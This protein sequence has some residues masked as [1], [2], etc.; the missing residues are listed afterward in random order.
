MNS[1]GYAG[2]CFLVAG[3][4]AAGTASAVGNDESTPE[5]GAFSLLLE[6]D[7]FARQDRHYTNGLQ[8]S[9]L[10]A[11]RPDGSLAAHAINWLPGNGNAKVR[12]G[13]QLG[14]SLFTP[15]DK[16]ASDLLPDERPYAGWLYAGFSL[17]SSTAVHVD[18]WS[19]LAG[20]TGPDAKG[21][22]VQNHVH[23]WIDATNANGWEH[24]IGN[25]A[26]GML[27]IERKWR[28]LA[29]TRVYRF[30]VDF[31]PHLGVALGNIEQYANAG[32]SLRIGNDLDNDFGPPRIR[33]SLPGSGWFDPHDGW[34]WYL[35][36]GVD[37]RYIDKSIFIDDHADSGRW[38]IEKEPWVADMQGGLVMTYGDFRFAYTYVVRTEEFN[39]QPEP[40]RFGSLALTWRF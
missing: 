31:M 19:L 28:A 39:L 12:I 36:A 38:N 15:N 34:S 24:Q 5:R 37:G 1:I 33:P 26:G 40:D 32:F 21:E 13:W 14:Q 35:F 17:V 3:L 22:E 16:E 20:T 10:T 29:Q 7:E 4:A 25:Q 23:E 11:P 8:L 27:I 30:G 18:T 2:A 9:W 6:N